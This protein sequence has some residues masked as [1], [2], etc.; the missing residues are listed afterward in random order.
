MTIEAIAA[1]LDGLQH[2][3][4]KKLGPNSDV[5]QPLPDHIRAGAVPANPL[6]EGRIRIG[7][8]ALSSILVA[9]GGIQINAFC[10]GVL[11]SKGVALTGVYGV[12]LVVGHYSF[13]ALN[14]VA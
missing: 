3:D 10:F 1:W 5:L 4:K 6:S 2:N 8:R 12:S 9:P 7:F 13:R 14:P 11:P